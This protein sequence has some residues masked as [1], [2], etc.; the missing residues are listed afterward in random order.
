MKR[1]STDGSDFLFFVI[2]LIILFFFFY[3]EPDVMTAL[4]ESTIESL[5]EAEQ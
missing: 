3:G 2:G 5:L 4:R 1:G